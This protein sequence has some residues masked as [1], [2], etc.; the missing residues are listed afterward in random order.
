MYLMRIV[1]VII[2][3]AFLI[4]SYWVSYLV[5]QR[6]FSAIGMNYAV[7]N[8]T[9]NTFMILLVSTGLSA[10]GIFCMGLLAI[11]TNFVFV[12]LTFVDEIKQNA[13][14]MLR[15]KKKSPELREYQDN[16]KKLNDK[17]SKGWSKFVALVTKYVN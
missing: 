3:C 8:N 5:F 9:E 17:E 7:D 15:E 2:T 6:H 4:S 10:V 16:L 12:K 11:F 1:K 14:M 13:Y